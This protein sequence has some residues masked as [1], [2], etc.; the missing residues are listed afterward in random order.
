MNYNKMPEYT[1]PPMPEE[2][3]TRS[4]LVEFGNYLL[5]EERKS[6]YTGDNVEERLS[7]VNHADV[8]NWLNLAVEQN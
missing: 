1:P 4:Q 8:E 2:K 5:S 3:F 7:Q 6:F